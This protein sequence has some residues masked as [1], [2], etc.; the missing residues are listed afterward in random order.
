[1]TRRGRGGSD[2]W[3][4][5]KATVTPLR[6]RPTIETQVP[7]AEALPRA[8]TPARN[9][10]RASVP[11]SRRPPPTPP[12][13]RL[14]AIEPRRLRRIG[15]GAEEIAGRIDL[16][17]HTQVGAH[18]ALVERILR[19]HAAGARAVLVITGKGIAG[20]GILRRRV[21]QWLAQPPLRAVVAGI[22]PAGRS[23]GGAGALYVA[24]RRRE[25]G[26]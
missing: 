6:G 26:A 20:N 18:A 7:P 9:G 15:R 8:K 23:H 17:G 5:V 14:H 12:T 22:S 16:H 11:Q 19:L 21:P 2:L 24:L 13:P 3:A 10:P 25:R 1:M 4:E